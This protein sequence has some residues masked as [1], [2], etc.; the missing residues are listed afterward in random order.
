MTTF[1]PANFNALRIGAGE[2]IHNLS[3]LVILM[4]GL[5]LTGIVISFALQLVRRGD[6]PGIE[7]LSD[8]AKWGR[9][10]VEGGEARPGASRAIGSWKRN[11]KD[12]EQAG[13]ESVMASFATDRA[14]SGK[15][16]DFSAQQVSEAEHSAGW[17]YTQYVTRNSKTKVGG[18]G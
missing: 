17:G 16:S 13:L 18:E 8:H 10:R 15:H 14:G 6:A 2:V 3:P 5:A 12:R 7:A 11:K 1:L 9:G 4:G